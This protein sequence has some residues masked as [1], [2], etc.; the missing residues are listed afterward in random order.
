[1][2]DAPP[3]QALDP[4]LI[5]AVA[6]DMDLDI[7]RKILEMVNDKFSGDSQSFIET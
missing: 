4:S 1:M 6:K 5:V 3:P 7:A 2:D